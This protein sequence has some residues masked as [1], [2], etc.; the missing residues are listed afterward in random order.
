M[1]EAK[2]Q[3]KLFFNRLMLAFLAAI[4]TISTVNAQV[5]SVTGVVKDALGE[6][7][8]GASVIVKGTKAA[9]ITNVDGAYNLNVPS[10]GKVLVVSYIGMESQE[11]PIKGTVIN[12]T[13]QSV[14]KSLDE[15]VVIGYGT[16]KRKDITGSISSVKAEELASIPVSSVAEAISGKLAGVQV[17]TTEGSPDADR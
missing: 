9:T 17:T 15:V 16:A 11:V 7:I 2:P 5:K 10:E 6:T 3:K 12:V 8:I 13:L 4:F 1:K 14:D